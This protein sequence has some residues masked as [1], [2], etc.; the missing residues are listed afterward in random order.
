MKQHRTQDNLHDKAREGANSP[1]TAMPFQAQI[2]KSFGGH[3]ISD[4]R[5]HMNAD[6]TGSMGA[7]AYAYGND[8]VFGSQPDMHTAAHE[9]AHTVQQKGG[10]NLAGGVGQEGD[11]YE[12]NADA[13]ADAVVGGQSAESLLDP[14]GGGGV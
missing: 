5:A 10:V 4:V 7:E 12:Q 6:A 14:F 2:Q 3:D 13:V 11:R 1:G 8:V 9:A